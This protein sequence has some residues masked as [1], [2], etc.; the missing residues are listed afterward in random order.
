LTRTW[1]NC[2]VGLAAI[3][4]GRE[5]RHPDANVAALTADA[6]D[7]A[8]WSSFTKTFSDSFGSAVAYGLVAFVG[9]WIFNSWFI[10]DQIG[11]MRP[12]LKDECELDQPKNCYSVANCLSD[13]VAISGH[14]D[15]TDSK[16]Q[17]VRLF[18]IG[19]SAVGGVSAGGFHCVWEVQPIHG[20]DTQIPLKVNVE[21]ACVKANR[22]G[23]TVALGH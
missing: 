5:D 4:D 23:Y 2:L 13:E 7:Q 11:Q 9:A 3:G 22:F 14:C 19:T 17:P 18:N 6:A 12:A 10:H 1:R 15:V 20:P 16:S 8:M 21:A